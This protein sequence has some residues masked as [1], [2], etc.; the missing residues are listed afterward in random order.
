MKIN[1]LLAKKMLAESKPTHRDYKIIMSGSTPLLFEVNGSRL[2]EIDDDLITILTDNSIKDI[3]KQIIIK[4]KLDTNHIY[5][6]DKPIQNP[7]TYAISLAIAQKCNL[8]CSYCYASQGEFGEA[9]KKMDISMAKTAIDFLLVDKIHGEKVQISFMGGE[10]LMNR[11]G[12]YEA[13]EYAFQQAF[14]KDIDVNFSITTNGTLLTEEDAFFF[15]K[16]GFAVTISLDGN[17]QNHDL[18]R[19]MKNGKGTFDIIMRK[20]APLLQLQN[21]MQ[22]SARITV[23]SENLNVSNTLKEFISM[24]FHSVGLSPL[25]NANNHS[26]ELSKDQQEHLLAEMI[27]CGLEFEKAVM[28]SEP[29]PFLNMINAFKEIEKQTHKPYPC[30]AG[31]GYLGVSASGDLSACH[32]FVNNSEGEMGSLSKGL[33]NDKQNSWLEQRHVHNQKPCTSCWARY[34]CGGGCHHE[35]I[36]VGRT[37]CDYIRGWLTFCLQSYNRVNRLIEKKVHETI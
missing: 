34:L 37:S 16:Y 14:I 33:D 3:D 1:Q 19:P 9:A 20:I 27:E 35:V 10:P 36:D 32:R 21:K 12:I 29:F 6:D 4:S 17:K 26:N 22:V 31:A 23:T 2:I 8:G 18:L 25:L 7:K 28:K 13:T 30:G 5:V 15:E 24:G 11:K